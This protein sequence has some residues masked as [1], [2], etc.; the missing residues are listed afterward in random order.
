MAGFKNHDV[1]G[2]RRR[3]WK[4]SRE[5]NTTIALGTIWRDPVKNK[6]H[7]TVCNPIVLLEY[8]FTQEKGNPMSI[9]ALIW[10]VYGSLTPN[11]HEATVG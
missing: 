8:L 2:W 5:G 7:V 10:N 1:E 9:K 6:Q 3:G 11:S 4:P